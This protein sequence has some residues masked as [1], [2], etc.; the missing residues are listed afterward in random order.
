MCQGR[1]VD[2][3][4][5]NVGLERVGVSPGADSSNNATRIEAGLSGTAQNIILI[6]AVCGNLRDGKPA[7]ASACQDISGIK[8]IAVFIM[9]GESNYRRAAYCHTRYGGLN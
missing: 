7:S 1:V 4:L 2:R 5:R 6:V 9:K 8:W 3:I